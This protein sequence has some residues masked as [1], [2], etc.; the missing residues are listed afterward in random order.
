MNSLHKLLVAYKLLACRLHDPKCELAFSFYPDYPTISSTVNHSREDAVLWVASQNI[1]L[2]NL[3]RDYERASCDFAEI[4]MLYPVPTKRPSELK[5]VFGSYSLLVAFEA[6]KL[7]PV[8]HILR[9]KHVLSQ[10][11]DY[12]TYTLTIYEYRVAYIKAYL[13]SKLGIGHL[14][15]LTA[16]YILDIYYTELERLENYEGI[17]GSR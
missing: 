16:H 12:R 13:A 7:Y 9:F 4:F 10:D 2:S 14:D 5:K 15:A 17:E 1:R 6:T 8:E 3:Y 11:G